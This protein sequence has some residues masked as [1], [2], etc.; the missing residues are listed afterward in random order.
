MLSAH[1]ELRFVSSKQSCA[2]AF[3]DLRAEITDEVNRKLFKNRIVNVRDEQTLKFRKEVHLSADFQALWEKI[4]HRTRYRVTF[5]TA[6]LIERALGGDVMSRGK[7]NGVPRAVRPA[8]T[9]EPA[10][11]YKTPVTPEEAFQAIGR[12]RKEA[13]DEID[14]G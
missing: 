5:E 12:L 2:G 1:L 6:D 3:A 9:P 8:A 4:K 14:R 13:R 10:I 7:G 11:Y